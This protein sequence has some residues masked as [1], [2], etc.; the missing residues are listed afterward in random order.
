KREKTSKSKRIAIIEGI[1]EKGI[2]NRFKKIRLHARKAGI[3]SLDTENVEEFAYAM[4]LELHPKLSGGMFSDKTKKQIFTRIDEQS[5]AKEQRE[6]RS[7]KLKALNVAQEM[8]ESDMIKFADAM[9]W[10]SSDDPII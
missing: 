1:D 6:F 8:S 7:A 5:A 4:F 9:M 3:L 10:D 2:P